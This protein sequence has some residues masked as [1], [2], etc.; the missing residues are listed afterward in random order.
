M[1]KPMS[2]YPKPRKTKK[3]KMTEPMSQYPKPR[4]KK[5]KKKMA[6]PMS[7][8]LAWGQH[9]CFFVF[10][11]FSRFLHYSGTVSKTSKNKK[12]QKKWQNPC[13]SIQNLEKPKKNKMAE[14]MSQYLAWGQHFFLVF[15]GFGNTLGGYQKPR[16]TKKQKKWQNPCPSIWH[17]VSTFFCFFGFLVFRGFCSTLGG[18]QKPRKTKKTKNKMAEPMSQYLAWGQHFCFFCFFG[19]L[20]FRGFGNTLG[21]YQK[22]RKNKKQKKQNGRT[23]VPVSGMGSEL[24]FFLVCGGFCNILVSDMDSAILLFWFLKVFAVFGLS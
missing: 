10:F 14:P 4:K 12:T 24:L 6:E 23:Y 21:G 3:K 8:Y 5:K 1:A 19:F 22:P 20:V 17:G 13:P 11:G 2:Q 9:F 16:K 15:R 7:Q 18:Y